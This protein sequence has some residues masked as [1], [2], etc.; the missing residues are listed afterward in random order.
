MT[1]VQHGTTSSLGSTYARRSGVGTTPTWAH[2]H[3]LVDPSHWHRNAIA[4]CLAW[5]FL[6]IAMATGDAFAREFA[7]PEVEFHST[8]AGVLVA[9]CAPRRAPTRDYFFFNVR[10][11]SHYFALQKCRTNLSAFLHDKVNYY[12]W[13]H[14]KD[15]VLHCD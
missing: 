2:G 5:R 3:R 12:L 15:S 7:A 14:L 13:G 11:P 10:G 4:I 1:A 6:P 8:L 9:M